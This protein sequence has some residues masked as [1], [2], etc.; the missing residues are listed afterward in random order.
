MGLRAEGSCQTA[1]GGPQNCTAKVV[2]TGPDIILDVNDSSGIPGCL[3]LMAG[4]P[5]DFAQNGPVIFQS[6]RSATQSFSASGYAVR[7]T[8]MIR[9]KRLQQT[10]TDLPPSAR[11]PLN[12]GRL[13]DVLRN[14]YAIAARLECAMADGDQRI[15]SIV[16]DTDLST[17][18]RFV[19]K[20]SS[21]P[22][23]DVLTY[24]VMP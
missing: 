14:R 16:G 2:P 22:T 11:F 20:N 18:I 9:Q 6:Q 23:F 4:D 21:E 13:F 10:T 24:R 19:S 1:E 17:N 5:C 8:T 15:F 3:A 7:M 12:P